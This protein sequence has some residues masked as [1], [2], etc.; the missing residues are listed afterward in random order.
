M[1]I[2]FASYDYI[3]TAFSGGKDSVACV[4][5][6]LD[7]GAPRER[8]ELWH[9][10]VDGRE[11]LVIETN[12]ETSTIE[13]DLGE[14]FVGLMMAF[15]DPED[16]ELEEML[17]QIRFLFVIDD[18]TSESVTWFDSEAGFTRRHNMV[19]GTNLLIDMNVPDEATGELAGMM[20]D[21]R[22][23]QAIDYRLVSSPSA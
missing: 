7:A 1:T 13:F 4:L 22:L 10:E 19:A 2:D 12:T 16:P 14:F 15:G 20:V 18:A 3:I 5:S 9:H 23:D 17:E 8:M 11:V 6:L 21:M